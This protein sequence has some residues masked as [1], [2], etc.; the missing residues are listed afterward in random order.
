MIQHTVSFV[1]RHPSDSTEERAFLTDA[2][3]ILPAIPGVENFRISRQVSEKSS[4]DFQFSMEFPDA[5][6]YAAYNG[7]PAHVQFVETRWV[8]EV[9]DFQ[10]LDLVPFSRG[11]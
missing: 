4:H 11:R 8:P 10:E 7:H 5:A 9:A 3:A 2:A 6:A 1:L